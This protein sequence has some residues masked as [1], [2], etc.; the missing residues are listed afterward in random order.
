[1]NPMMDEREAAKVLGCSVALLRKW[2]LYRQDPECQGP[3]YCKIGRLVRYSQADIAAF[4]EG[5]RQGA[6]EA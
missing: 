5:H 6:G 2:R 4:I 3:A 1:M